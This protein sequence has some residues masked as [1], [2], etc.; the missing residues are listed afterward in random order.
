MVLF[1]DLCTFFSTALCSM[2]LSVH[3]IHKLKYKNT[4]GLSFRLIISSIATYNY[5]L[6]KFL[7]SC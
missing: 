1:V 6:V 3:E 2:S 7:Y 4:N 5:N